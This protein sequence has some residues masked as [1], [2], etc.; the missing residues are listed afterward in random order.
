MYYDISKLKKQR[1]YCKAY[2]QTFTAKSPYIQSRCTISN[3]VI[4]I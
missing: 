2:Q 3:E 1:F 4:H